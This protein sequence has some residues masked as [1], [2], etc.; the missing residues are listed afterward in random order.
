MNDQKQYERAQTYLHSAVFPLLEE[1]VDLPRA[2]KVII[3]GCGYSGICIAHK[4]SKGLKNAEIVMYD[5]NADFGGT[6]LENTYPGVTCD[7]PAH[8]YQFSF[9]TNPDWSKFYVEG[10]EIR[11]YL[12]KC[13]DK[14][15]V[16]PFAKFNHEIKG[17]TWNEQDGKWKLVVRQNDT[18]T[19][20]EDEADVVVSATGFL[21]HWK[22]PAIDGLDTF[23]GK[24][25]HSAKWTLESVEDPVWNERRVAVIG[26]GSSGTQIVSQ[27]QPHVAQ[28]DNYV[29]S[30][31]WISRPIGAMLLQQFPDGNTG[32]HTFTDEEKASFR[33]N[34]ASYKALLLQIE[35]FNQ[36]VHAGTLTGTGV[37]QFLGKV[38]EKGMR[39]KLA[40]RPDIEEAIMPDFPVFCRRLTPG[41]G[42]LEALMSENASLVT[43]PIARITST[44]IETTDGTHREYDVI[45]AATGFD[46]TYVPRYPIIGQREVNL[47]DR[48]REHPKT[49]LGLAQDSF[50][51]WFQMA[52]PNTT[53]ATGSLL[54]VLEAQADYIVSCLRKIQRERIKWMAPKRKAVD[55]F[56][57]FLD[58]YFPRTVWAGKCRTWYKGGQED[59]RVTALW[60]G[61]SLHQFQ[62]LQQPRFEDYEYGYTHDTG[63]TNGLY[64]LGNGF[65]KAEMD[66]IPGTR[67]WLVES[68]FSEENML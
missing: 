54:T 32:N 44:G 14:L 66:G 24:L 40:S 65:T 27:L 53:V 16:R 36:S 68:S 1:P 60:P 33:K 22:W 30:R 42:Y 28:L 10:P 52:G 7:I 38:F 6:W 3:I 67:A 5:K 64:W 25:T 35:D 12:N 41:V 15:G 43:Q 9:A 50:P 21:N 46:T 13:A 47:Q 55:D 49:Y 62:V 57:A 39:D 4:L 18:G 58:S 26:G 56:Q 61:S 37:H 45:V 2:M 59:A 20:V 51:N 48:W 63:N 19:E 31:T 8:A 23:E 11:Q 34:P 29:R 17:A